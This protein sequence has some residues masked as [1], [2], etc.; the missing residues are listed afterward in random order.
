MSAHRRYE[1]EN[2][3]LTK[4]SSYVGGVRVDAWFCART[5]H[6]PG[7][8]MSSVV[9]EGIGSPHPPNPP[10]AHLHPS[11]IHLEVAAS[12]LAGHRYVV[13]RQ[14]S[15]P[16]QAAGPCEPIATKR[17]RVG[18]QGRRRDVS[19][20][21]TCVTQ[22]A[23][24]ADASDRLRSD[25]RRKRAPTH[26]SPHPLHILTSSSSLASIYSPGPLFSPST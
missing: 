6:D 25:A 20:E 9:V 5:R 14:N 8:G 13:S 15:S 1:K 4:T 17:P 3:V 7:K 10:P 12:L 23:I 26:P 11:R 18:E 21:G 22:R 2:Q 19:P 16:T 24:D